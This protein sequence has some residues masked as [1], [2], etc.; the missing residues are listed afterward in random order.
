MVTILDERMAEDRINWK[1]MERLVQG[2]FFLTYKDANVATL[3]RDNVIKKLVDALIK[4]LEF[5]Q[6][7][8]IILVVKVLTFFSNDEVT[9]S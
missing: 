3:K 5:K 8:L 7:E 9:W 2:F 6:V 4:A 1:I